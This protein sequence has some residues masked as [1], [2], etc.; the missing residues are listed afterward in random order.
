MQTDSTMWELSTHVRAERYFIIRVKEDQSSRQHQTGIIYWCSTEQNLTET[1]G[2]LSNGS[3]G[4]SLRAPRHVKC[5][6]IAS[7]W[8]SVWKKA[9]QELHHHNRG[10]AAERLRAPCSLIWSTQ[11]TQTLQFLPSIWVERVSRKTAC[12][13]KH[14]IRTLKKYW[15]LKLIHIFP[16]DIWWLWGFGSS[17]K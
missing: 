14:L 2:V 10:T 8:A 11:K 15:N 7:V 5:L 6:H 13:K 3:E 9:C 17:S 1:G 4:L 12:L 16:L